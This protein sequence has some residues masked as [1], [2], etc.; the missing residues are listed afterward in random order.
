MDRH[1]LT[2]RT[3]MPRTRII[4]LPTMRD[5]AAACERFQ[6]SWTDDERQ[7]RIDGPANAQHH[8]PM[9]APLERWQP[10]KICI[11]RFGVVQVIAS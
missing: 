6:R 5:I 3:H 4:Y 9:A 8:A 10:P 11:N 7:R 2:G 1:I